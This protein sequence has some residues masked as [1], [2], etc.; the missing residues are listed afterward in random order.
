MVERYTRED[1]KVA[2]LISPGYGA[3][4]STWAS[5]EDVE[6]FLFDATMVKAVL[7][8]FRQI[9]G[10]LAT[11][12]TYCPKKNQSDSSNELDIASAGADSK[13]GDPAGIVDAE[14]KGLNAKPIDCRNSVARS[15]S[16]GLVKDDASKT[17]TVS[18]TTNLPTITSGNGTESLNVDAHNDDS[19]ECHARDDMYSSSAC[20]LIIEWLDPGEEF[21]VNEYDGFESILRKRD[22][23]GY[24]A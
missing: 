22:W 9:A 5:D 2:V 15:E 1:G 8:G 12:R 24:V 14:A 6:F 3:G 20:T 21:T 19:Y 11:M 10:S 16:A 13:G 7:A 18:E 23:K 4:W 17:E